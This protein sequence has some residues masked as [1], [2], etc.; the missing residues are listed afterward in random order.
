MDVY[1]IQFGSAVEQPDNSCQTPCKHVVGNVMTIF[2]SGSTATCRQVLTQGN[3]GIPCDFAVMVLQWSVTHYM[4]LFVFDVT[5]VGANAPA[6][7][8]EAIAVLFSDFS[9]STNGKRIHHIG[10]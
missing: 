3:V 5:D 8:N 2:S 4:Q 7:V 6:R 1:Q 9:V 10:C